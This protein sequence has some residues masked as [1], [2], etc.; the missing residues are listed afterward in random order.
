MA[1][2]KIERSCVIKS[3]ICTITILHS[4]LGFQECMGDVFHGE[5]IAFDCPQSISSL[6]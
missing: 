3:K 2:L 5:M 1:L 6:L 4:L